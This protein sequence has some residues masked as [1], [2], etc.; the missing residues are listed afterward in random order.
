[1]WNREMMEL[2][3]LTEILFI[4]S[5]TDSRVGDNKWRYSANNDAKKMEAILFFMG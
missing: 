4:S 2:V 3:K 5:H 1:M